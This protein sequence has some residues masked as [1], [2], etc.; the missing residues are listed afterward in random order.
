MW[1]YTSICTHSPLPPP[2]LE[3]GIAELVFQRAAYVPLSRIKPSRSFI[4][5][6]ECFYSAV[7]AVLTGRV[8]VF[9]RV[10]LFRLSDIVDFGISLSFDVRGICFSRRCRVVPL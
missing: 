7:G 3:R 4:L 9:V 2:L 8:D 6:G 1:E 5:C 10:F